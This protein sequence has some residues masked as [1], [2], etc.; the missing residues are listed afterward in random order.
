M[1]SNV[2]S[3]CLLPSNAGRENRELENIFEIILIECP[4]LS[5]LKNIHAKTVS[6]NVVSI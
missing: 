1:R 4:I 6:P 3:A 2:S 5:A